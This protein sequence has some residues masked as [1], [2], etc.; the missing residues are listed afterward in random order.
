[1]SQKPGGVP[2][3]NM[4]SM[5]TGMGMGSAGGGGSNILNR[6]TQSPSGQ[7]LQN[8]PGSLSPTKADPFGNLLNFGGASGKSSPVIAGTLEEQRIAKEAEIRRKNEEAMR[9]YGSL[10]S[11][12]VGGG[13]GISAANKKDTD[14]SAFWKGG[15]N[16]AAS[17]SRGASPSILTPQKPGQSATSKPATVTSPGEDAFS[18][19]LHPTP[20]HAKLGKDKERIEQLERQNTP[21]DKL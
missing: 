9:G 3:P 7:P 19:L 4:N 2:G 10:G 17:I 20:M 1:M 15:A 8:S 12:A 16:S 5:G 11:M 21:L 6:Q 14:N 13:E 18:S